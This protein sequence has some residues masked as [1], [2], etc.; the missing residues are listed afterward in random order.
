MTRYHFFSHI[1]NLNTGSLVLGNPFEEAR[2]Q[3]LVCRYQLHRASEQILDPDPER[4]GVS[5]WRKLLP[6]GEVHTLSEKPVLQTT[7]LSTPV[8]AALSE[9]RYNQELPFTI[10]LPAAR[11]AG[12]ENGFCTATHLSEQC[13]TGLSEGRARV[14][15]PFGFE[16]GLPQAVAALE[17]ERAVKADFGPWGNPYRLE[18]L[19][20][21]GLDIIRQYSGFRP[22]LIVHDPTGELVMALE[23][24]AMAFRMFYGE[25]PFRT[26]L[27]QEKPH[28]ILCS[29]FEGL[30]PNWSALDVPGNQ[31][32][33]Q[34]P[35][36]FLHEI[37]QHLTTHMGSAIA[38]EPGGDIFEGALELL[39]RT[40]FVDDEDSVLLL[41]HD[42]TFDPS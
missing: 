5:S 24:A 11:D 19:K 37:V 35:T 36:P 15:G 40:G 41:G 1:E 42:L 32:A 20:L 12:F 23:L 39:T 34:P 9:L 33:L 14:D 3:A 25:P 18:G 38:A 22:T 21:I 6:L 8:C 16:Q 31:L 4:I 27:V 2:D 10:A 28:A 30:S 13:L 29:A 7:S 17:G 26:I